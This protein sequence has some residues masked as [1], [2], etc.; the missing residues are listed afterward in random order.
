MFVERTKKVENHFAMAKIL[1]SIQ[2]S[3]I[4]L[5]IY[6]IQI[7]EWEILKLTLQHYTYS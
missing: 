4:P 2:I 7:N 1:K 6:N 3:I 5:N